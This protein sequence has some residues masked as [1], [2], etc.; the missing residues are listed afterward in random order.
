MPF[1]VIL[2]L[3]SLEIHYFQNLKKEEE[4]NMFETFHWKRS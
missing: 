3:L 2:Y 4:K 1:I